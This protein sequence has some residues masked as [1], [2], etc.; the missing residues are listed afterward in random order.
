[1]ASASILH[2][3]GHG[4]EEMPLLL[5]RPLGP[6]PGI[7]YPLMP[8]SYGQ[9]IFPNSNYSMVGST[10]G[11]NLDPM[12]GQPLQLSILSGYPFL[13]Q[14][15]GML[16]PTSI[17]PR[18]ADLLALLDIDEEECPL[19]VEPPSHSSWVVMGGMIPTITVSS[20]VVETTL[21]TSPRSTPRVSTSSANVAGGDVWRVIQQCPLTSPNMALIG[22]GVGRGNVIAKKLM[23]VGIGKG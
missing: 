14:S 4:L 10:M 1:M 7:P 17:S 19:V 13:S 11:Y 21:S 15:S 20:S 3:L 6:P 18:L 23:K 22:A 9:R 8:M 12:M 2:S 16:F 5:S